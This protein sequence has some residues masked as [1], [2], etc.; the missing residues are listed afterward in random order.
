MIEE[1]EIEIAWTQYRLI[2]GRWT[3]KADLQDICYAHFKAGFLMGHGFNL[4][5]SGFSPHAWAGLSLETTA[6]EEILA[7][8]DFL[9]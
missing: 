8:E 7:D 3:K 2:I 9:L 5:A 6:Y 1:V 4:E